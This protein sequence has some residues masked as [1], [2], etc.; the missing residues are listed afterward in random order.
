MENRLVPTNL[1]LSDIQLVDGYNQPLDSPVVGQQI[2]IRAT[3]EATEISTSDSFKVRYFVDDVFVETPVIQGNKG[4]HY[5][6]MGTTYASPGSHLITVKLDALNTLQETNE[7]DNQQTLMTTTT[8]PMSLPQKFQFPLLGV[9]NRDWSITN[10]VD[11]DPQPDSRTDYLGGSFQYEGHN[12]MDISLANY[13]AQDAGVPIVAAAFGTVI[14]V[15]DGSFDRESDMSTRPG[16]HL[17]IDHGAGWQTTYY[18]FAANSI[19]VKVGDRVKQGDLLGLVG[20]SGMSTMS[21]LHWSVSYKGANVETGFSSIS[22]WKSAPLYQGSQLPTVMFSGITNNELGRDIY[23][24]PSKVQIF[25]IS[26]DWRVNYF[27]VLSNFR[28]NSKFQVNW[29]QPDGTLYWSFDRTPERPQESYWQWYISDGWKS[30]LG[31]WHV[32]L[33]V[34]GREIDRQS[35][36]VVKEG[37]VPELEVYQDLNYIVSKRMTPVEFGSG[38]ELGQ[39][40]SKQWILTNRGAADLS[41]SDLRLP[42]GFFAKDPFDFTIKPGESRSFSIQLDTSLPGK[43]LGE[44]RFSTNDADER[45]FSF[46]VEG[47]VDGSIPDAVPILQL[48]SRAIAYVFGQIPALI[49]PDAEIATPSA[50]NWENCTV[51]VEILANASPWDEIGIRQANGVGISQS[52]ITYFGLPI[53]TFQG[54]K[55]HFQIQFLRGAFGKQAVESVLR[56]LTY[57]NTSQGVDSRPRFLGISLQNALGQ[58]SDLTVKRTSIRWAVPSQGIVMGSSSG[59]GPSSTVT[60]FNSKGEVSA[61]LVPFTGFKGVIRTAVGDVNGD[62]TDDIVAASGPGI[63]PIVKIFDGASNKELSSFRPFGA[64]FHGGLSVAVGDTNGDGFADIMIGTQS[65]GN[66]IAIFS[67]LNFS[68]LKDF[69]P[70]GLNYQGGVNLA[71]GD[72]NADGFSD[73]IIGA[74]TGSTRVVVI[75]VSSTGLGKF[76]IFRSFFAMNS[77]ALSGGVLVAAG[78]I[79]KDG[80]CDILI[81]SGQGAVDPQLRIFSGENNKL[82]ITI[83]LNNRFLN[84]SRVTFGDINGD[85]VAEIIAGSGPTSLPVIFAFDRSSKIK[86][87]ELAIKSGQ[88]KGGI[89]F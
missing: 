16:N 18:H 88:N 83:R 15:G 11:V 38:I 50:F 7:E 35:F 52:R 32:A 25:P 68:K 3:W 40:V 86:L 46:V 71:F 24:S 57:R 43:K 78:D 67:G 1:R 34:D 28:P 48:N 23:E 80:I 47:Q 73:A 5:W 82:L 41:V 44:V 61:T 2:F 56:N 65:G 10:Y 37:G 59:V 17:I 72:I 6:Y 76:T 84:G 39:L 9:Q 89:V 36:E 87:K 19:V 53:A 77:S 21:H 63:S 74:S 42:A 54:G 45:E 8:E 4:H 69:L 85:G 20:S 33:V 64:G 22:Y 62:G 75:D 14:E 12:G 51:R 66:H 13:A 79:D 49:A 58:S 70:F 26:A 55:T 29:Y 60:I 30:A 81:G 27:F 31:I